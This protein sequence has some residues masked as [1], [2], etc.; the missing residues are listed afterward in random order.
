MLAGKRL[1]F[2]TRLGP[3][4][5]TDAGNSSP[6]VEVFAYAEYE[7][8]VDWS[9][10]RRIVDVGAHVGS[11]TTWAAWRAPSATILAVEPEPANFAD[12]SANVARNGLSQRVECV[13]GAV[14]AGSGTI[15]LHVPLYRESGSALAT[16]G[17]VVTVQAVTLTELLDRSS[18]Q[19]GLLKI[20]CE[21]AE[22]PVVEALPPE[23]WGK[24]DAIVMEC[25][26]R[27]GRSLEE[28]QAL[29]GERGFD[30]E[31]QSRGPASVPWFDEVGVL[32]AH[33]PDGYSSSA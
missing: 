32:W 17:T 19:V 33:R 16:R 22:W 28:M 6:I 7:L 10:L 31:I 18:G 4:L 26:T 13:N 25:H 5:E 3:V 9:K 21:G 12:L 11:F 27:G 20:D 14:A 29:L 8:P 15:E 24:V 2:A 30:V 1:R 23:Y